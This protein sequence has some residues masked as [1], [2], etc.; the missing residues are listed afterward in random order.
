MMSRYRE[1]Q[2]AKADFAS[3]G[4]V[5]A[6]TLSCQKRSQ[7][8]KK[9]DTGARSVFG[10]RACGYVHMNVRFIEYRLCYTQHF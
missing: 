8:G 9:R 5:L 6:N 2:A 4:Q 10:Y 7:R 1:Y 3:H